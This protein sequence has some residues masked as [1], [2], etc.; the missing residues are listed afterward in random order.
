MLGQGQLVVERPL[1]LGHLPGPRRLEVVT[2][3]LALGVH[4]EVG[5]QLG[6]HLQL[7]VWSRPL[8]WR[9]GGTWL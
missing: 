1:L 4:G 3:R 2:D 6:G 7:A 8:V 5:L 9:T